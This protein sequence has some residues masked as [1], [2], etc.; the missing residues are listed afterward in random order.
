MKNCNKKYRDM[1]EFL[2]KFKS[3]SV[4]FTHFGYDNAYMII[5][6]RLRNAKTL[7]EECDIMLRVIMNF[8]VFH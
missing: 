7:E 8:L 6:N 4:I 5:H 3:N 1:F 2:F